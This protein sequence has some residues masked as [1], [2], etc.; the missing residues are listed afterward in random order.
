M[1]RVLNTIVLSG[2][3]VSVIVLLAAATAC[4]SQASDS[5]SDT[6]QNSSAT[7]DRPRI[8]VTTN[9]LG[10]IVSAAVGDQAD[11]E[12]IMP[13]GTDPH[14]FAPSAR[15][16]ESMEDADLLIVNGAGF[17]QGMLDI[18]ANVS[19]TGTE[20]FS[21][22]DHVELLEFTGDHD[23]GDDDHGD[24]EHADDEHADEDHA[25]HEG[26]QDPHLWTDPTRI[27]AAVA[28]LEPVVAGLSGVDAEAVATSFD[29][30]LDDL[31]ALDASMQ[32]T[33]AV[34]PATQ[35]ILV[36]NHEVFGY[37]A[38]RY[39]FDVIGT[40][41]PSLTTSA[42]SSASDIEALADLIDADGVPAVFGE[43]TQSST[44]TEVLADEVGES[45]EVVELFSESLGEEGSG[46]ETYLGMMQRNADLVAGA[47]T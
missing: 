33:L 22:A 30:Y 21:F 8:V 35:R 23:H 36:T 43:T 3:S 5:A 1:G 26:G 45:V 47:L 13:L 28:A 32:E 39:D 2:R 31:G 44:L 9:I 37:F 27:A 12:V 38:D 15:Q 18:V 16:A 40:I 10:D 11:V 41:I 24:D 25:D 20:V 42:E 29:G 6:D 4:G 14:D 34:V 7:A 19:D 46:A 17:E